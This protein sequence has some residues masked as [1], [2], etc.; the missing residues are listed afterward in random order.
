M[1]MSR[2]DVITTI[3]PHNNRI[4]NGKNN[5]TPKKK[6]QNAVISKKYEV[7][8]AGLFYLVI[9][10]ALMCEIEDRLLKQSHNQHQAQ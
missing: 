7:D 3:K 5:I 6:P 8:H 4:L 10:V 2:F 1:L 9:Y